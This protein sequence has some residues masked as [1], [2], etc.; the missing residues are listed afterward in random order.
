MAAVDVAFDVTMNREAV[1]YADD[2]IEAG[3]IEDGGSWSGPSPDA[4]NDLIES[5]G[6]DDFGRWYLGRQSDADPESKAHYRY[7]FSDD[8]VNISVKGLKAIRSRSAQNDEEDI[9]A[10]AGRMLEAIEKKMAAETDRTVKTLHADPRRF[11]FQASIGKVDRASGVL[12]DVVII[13]AGEARGHRMMISERSVEAANELLR[14][15]SLPAYITHAGAYGDRLLNEIGVFSDFYRD[16]D[17]IR[18]ARFEIL[19]SFREAEPEQFARLFDLAERLPQTFGISIVFEGAMFWE[20]EDGVEEFTGYR[21]RP[22]DALFG[23][24]TITPT[25]IDSADFVDTPAATS[26]LFSESKR[27]KPF[28]GKDMDE[29]TNDQTETLTTLAESASAELE[30]RKAEEAGGS[31]E[32]EAAPAKPKKAAKK[33]KLEAAIATAPE[34]VDEKKADLSAEDL[35]AIDAIDAAIDAEFEPTSEAELRIAE[36]DVLIGQ[37][38]EQIEE[39]Q[40]QIETLKKVF[41]GTDE[42]DDD[43]AVLADAKP[44]DPKADA[45]TDYL[46][47]HPTHSRMTAVLQVAKKSP[48][49]FQ[50]N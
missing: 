15:V 39:L 25:R 32:P 20:T 7:P 46:K 2:L 45:I 21:E 34:S 11:T 5:E 22:E 49:L 13:E 6:W 10:A 19:P 9:F 28:Q 27:D 16:G 3:K 26:S 8:F 18:A 17:R 36:R 31:P 37:Q 43:L 24:P 38:Q 40:S 12:R 4:E 30:R 14:D 1:R 33:K 35:A 50:L 44:V 47:A 23:F 42:I 48:E 29:N 41:S